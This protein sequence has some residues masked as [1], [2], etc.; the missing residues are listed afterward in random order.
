LGYWRS[1]LDETNERRKQ[2]ISA[3]RAAFALIEVVDRARAEDEA[4]R[5]RGFEIKV[6]INSGPGVVEFV[7][8]GPN[9]ACTVMG[10][11]VNLAARLESVPP[12]YGC[13]IVLGEKT[14]KLV[15]DEF[16][17][18]ELDSIKVKGANEPMKVYQPIVEVAKATAEQKNLVTQYSQALALYRQMHFKQAC[19][20]WTQLLPLE[21][22]PSPS[23]IMF[24]R[25]IG[26]MQRPPAEPWNGVY[27]MTSK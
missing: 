6:G 23:S 3:V 17:L 5:Q 27:E 9:P 24:A 7:G 10:E 26:Y 4:R 14:A 2:A 21:P 1:S 12:Q 25:A 11:D 16:L 15:R 8:G 18:R 19:D 22:V 20:I 13:L